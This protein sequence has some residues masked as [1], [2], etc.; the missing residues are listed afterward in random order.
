MEANRVLE[1][2]VDPVASR[3]ASVQQVVRP[4]VVAG[5]LIQVVVAVVRVQV[6]KI[7]SCLAVEVQV[8]AVVVAEVLQKEDMAAEDMV[9]L[10]HIV[11]PE[12]LLMLLQVVVLV[13]ELGEVTKMIIFCK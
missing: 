4:P 5:H 10:E 8:A 1:D 6:A 2:M 12:H 7:L 13:A 9:E 3:V 11:V